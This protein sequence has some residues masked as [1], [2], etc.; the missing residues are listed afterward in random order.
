MPAQLRV[1]LETLL[2]DFTG[3]VFHGQNSVP[4]LKLL[5]RLRRMAPF[6]TYSRSNVEGFR[7]MSDKETF[8]PNYEV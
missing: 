3:V 7:K 2:T 4:A 5:L 6:W 8:G 1:V